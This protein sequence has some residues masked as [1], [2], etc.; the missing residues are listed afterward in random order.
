[1]RAVRRVKTEKKELP[2]STRS[3]TDLFA[4]KTLVAVGITAA[5]VILLLLIGA[6]ADVLLLIFAGIL[7]A[8]LL[9]SLSD[10][11]ASHTPL[12]AGWSLA[13]VL[14]LLLG[15]FGLC[16][17]SLAPDISQQFDQLIQ[18]IP[19]MVAQ[20]NRRLMQSQWGQQLLAQT[21]KAA[22]QLA[23]PAGLL[24][25]LA[26]LFSSTFGLLANV[27]IVFFIGLYLAIDPATYRNGVVRLFP[28]HRRERIAG[29][30]DQIGETLRWWMIA[31]MV[32]MI[33]I[34]VLTT[35]GLWFLDIQPAL[36]LGIVA[37]ILNF[38]P[39]IGPLLSAVPVLLITL[40]QDP[41]QLPY[42]LLL[43][44][45]VQSIDNHFVTPMV[46]RKAV[47]LPPVL[48]VTV[49]LILGVFVGALGVMFA[50]PLTASLLVAIKM[51]Y[52]EDTLGD[53]IEEA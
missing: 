19:Q 30:I 35:L 39:Y 4:R 50:S 53:R 27:V 51:L 37:G 20:L 45:A 7:L 24:S 2:P 1:M 38:V 13:A 29:V 9:R 22:E 44:I 31:R 15:L 42:A 23:K 34:G 33:V 10:W 6:A 11:I 16:G 12:S 36:A 25:G 5:V 14:F 32:A 41:T 26:A 21:P 43:Y 49:Q 28:L 3:N 40:G 17:W 8:V 47:N 52:V 46:E 18:N 48:T